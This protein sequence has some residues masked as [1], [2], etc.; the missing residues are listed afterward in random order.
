M[1]SADSPASKSTLRS[2]LDK[3]RRKL[4]SSSSSSSSDKQILDGSEAEFERKKERDVALERRK[5]EEERF[6]VKDRV[7]MNING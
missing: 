2:A 6:G 7:H 1:N 3:A 5:K 4:S